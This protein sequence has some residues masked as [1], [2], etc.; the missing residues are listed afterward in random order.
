MN[1]DD[2]APND[3]VPRAA[4]WILVPAAVATV[5]GLILLWPVGVEDTAI[6][7][8][9][10]EVDGH[11][12]SV[13]E[14]EC[15]AVDA[16]L[17]EQ[18]QATVCGDVLVRVDSGE[19]AGEQVI[20]GIPSGPGA[21]VVAAGDDV[22]LIHTPGS[23]SGQQFHIIDHDRSSAL[24]AL[25]IAFALAVVAFG[26]WKGLRSLVSLALTFA[27]VLVFMVPAVLDGSSPVLVAIVG[28][29]AIMLVSLYLSHGWNRTTTV[30]VLGTL[31]SLVLT[32]ALAEAS[33]R[34]AKLNGV[35]DENTTNLAMQ[36]PIDMSG[37][38]LAGILIGAL[39]VID[40]V[41]V[42][43]AATVDE[44]AKAN[45]RWGPAR[46]FKSGMRVGR[47]HLTSVVN[48]LV[49]AYAGASLPLLVLIAAANR[50]LEQVITSQ[51][52]ATEI[53]RS[54]AGTLG[55][56]AAVPITTWLA[57][58]LARRDPKPREPKAPKPKPPKPKPPKPDQESWDADESPYPPS[59]LR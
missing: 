33:V 2:T 59:H 23:V 1:H 26:R 53:V 35:L 48:T 32:V 16:E 45:P 40:D 29:A 36:Y 3:A 11:V 41:T 24:W 43:Q 18:L 31:A 28:A 9:G 52:I 5:L 14:T 21:P 57:A 46:L 4:L 50:P 13:H 30:A 27:V 42:S 6:E 54:V 56:I 8:F 25:G 17:N 20:L 49:L 7:G 51:T 37:L 22:I 19:F 47:D 15:E 12:V 39:G 58:T 55:L 10:T 44:V 38:L 34:L